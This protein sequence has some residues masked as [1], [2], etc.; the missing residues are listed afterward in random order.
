MRCSFRIDRKSTKSWR[1]ERS[2]ARARKAMTERSTVAVV[3]ALVAVLAAVA[4]LDADWTDLQLDVGDSDDSD[5][6]ELEA[7]LQSGEYDVDE[8]GPDGWTALH[9]TAVL[10]RPKMAS[11]LK[12][13][14]LSFSHS[15]HSFLSSIAKRSTGNIITHTH[16]E[17]EIWRVWKLN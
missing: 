1:I 13:Y 17:A 8:Q 6:D 15:S 4:A 7:D 14:F 3:V 16:S 10:D 9:L 2:A 5:T 12:R 11:M